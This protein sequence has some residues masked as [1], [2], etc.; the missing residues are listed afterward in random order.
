MGKRLFL[1]ITAIL[2][3]VAWTPEFLTAEDATGAKAPEFHAVET[4][5]EPEPEIEEV[6]TEVAWTA[7]TAEVVPV[8]YVPQVVNYTVTTYIGNINE[9]VNTASNLS[10]YDIYKFQK[11]IYGH[12]S[13]N[14]LGDL[15]GR[16]MGEVFTI[17]ENGVVRNYQVAGITIYAKTADGNLENDPS[18]MRNIA[19]GAMGH[20]VALMTCC[21]TSYGNGDASHRLVI[22][23]D[24]V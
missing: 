9:Y 15:S 3:G 5:V 1:L 8:A 11:L 14:L 17:T 12:N 7:P 24:A 18:L 10:Y 21:G 2:I 6:A 13:G 20:D 22:Y 19:Y 23:A 16:Y 4:V